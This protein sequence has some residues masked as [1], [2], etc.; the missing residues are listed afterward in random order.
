MFKENIL[1]ETM[2]VRALTLTVLEAIFIGWG[3]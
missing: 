1:S 2:E 3:L